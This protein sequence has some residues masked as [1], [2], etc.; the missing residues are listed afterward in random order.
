M[1]PTLNLPDLRPLSLQWQIPRESTDHATDNIRGEAVSGAPLT[2]S[3][4]R[5]IQRFNTIFF[6]ELQDHL[7]CH[8][9]IRRLPRID[10]NVRPLQQRAEI[11]CQASP[12]LK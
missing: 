5:D 2:R 12:T 4:P 11:P 3:R 10:Q 1:H 9:R 8:D 7:R 6:N